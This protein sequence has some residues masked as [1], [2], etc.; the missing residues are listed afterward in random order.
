MKFD[1]NDTA[2]VMIDPQNEVLSET[3]LGWPLLRESLHETIPSKIWIARLPGPRVRRRRNNS[4]K[5]VTH[6]DI[7]TS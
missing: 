6:H 7:I 2:V 4:R 3:G 1:K 5:F